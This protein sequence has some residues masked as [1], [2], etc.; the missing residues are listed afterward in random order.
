MEKKSDNFIDT[1]RQLLKLTRSKTKAIL[2]KGNLDKI[3]R[4]KEALG[5]IVKEL[6]ELKIQG[7][8]DKLQDG[9]AIEDVQKWGVDIEGEIDETDCEISHLNQYLT[10]TEARTE[11]EKREKEKILLQ[12]QRDE[13]LYFE[14][15][16]LEQMASLGSVS[17]KSTKAEQAKVSSVKMPKLVITKY[18]GTYERWLSFWNKFEAEIDNTLRE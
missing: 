9:E 6:E 1:E 10:E 15:C 3:I 11:N 17:V 7:E 8:K 18:D 5:K 14:K 4:H 12:Q 16:K 2:E 13:E